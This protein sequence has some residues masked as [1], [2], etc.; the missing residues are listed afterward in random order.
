MNVHDSRES[1]KWYW[2]SHE[3]TNLYFRMCWN[4]HMLCVCSNLS[5]ALVRGTTILFAR[6]MDVVQFFVKN[7]NNQGRL[8]CFLVLRKLLCNFQSSKIQAHSIVFL[9]STKLSLMIFLWP[10]WRYLPSRLNFSALLIVSS[11]ENARSVLSFVANVFRF[12][13]I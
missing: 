13:A 1:M 2:F 5:T 12:L 6:N 9:G 8:S 7:W 4:V 10:C 3:N 11:V